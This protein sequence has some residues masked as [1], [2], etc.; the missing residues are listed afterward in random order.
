[1]FSKDGSYELYGTETKNT[2]KGKYVFFNMG[3][4]EFLELRPSEPGGLSRITFR[5]N[6]SGETITLTRIRIGTRGIQELEPPV[7]LNKNS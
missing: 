2:Q 1:V 3:D 6:R 7:P 5:I 4:G